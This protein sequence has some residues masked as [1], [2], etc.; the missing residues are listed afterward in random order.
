M[1]VVDMASFILA[2]TDAAENSTGI[3]MPFNWLRSYHGLGKF[4]QPV[5]GIKKDFPYNIKLEAYVKNGERRVRAYLRHEPRG[6]FETPFDVWIHADKIPEMNDDT[7]FPL[8]NPILTAGRRKDIKKHVL[9]KMLKVRTLTDEQ[10]AWW[11]AIVAIDDSEN[12]NSKEAVASAADDAAPAAA[13]NPSAASAASAT[14]RAS[15]SRT[16]AKRANKRKSAPVP[17][18]ELERDGLG[19]GADG[20]GGDD[21]DTVMSPRSGMGVMFGHLTRFERAAMAVT[22]TP[23]NRP[24]TARLVTNEDI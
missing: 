4:V 10:R 2:C 8:I 18:L 23:R 24:R 11:D 16:P 20:G 6:D 12:A 5:E 15:S 17:P 19:D 9:D 7:L 14:A 1:S 3:E 22:G 13:A 21:T